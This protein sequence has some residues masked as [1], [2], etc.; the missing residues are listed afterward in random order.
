MTATSIAAP[1]LSALPA[2]I[3]KYRILRRLGEGATSEVFLGHDDFLGRDVAIKRVRASALADATDGRY[4]E[5][6]FA[7]KPPS[8]AASSIRTW[9]RSSTPSPTRTSPTS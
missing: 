3:G 1:D 6:F 5:R 9:C 2:R 7:A 4:Y 8:S